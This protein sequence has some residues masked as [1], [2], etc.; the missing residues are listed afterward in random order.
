MVSSQHIERIV[1]HRMV[2]HLLFWLLSFYVL[3][4]VFCTDDKYVETDL[5]YTFLFHI[6]LVFLVY[7]NL[8]FLLPRYFKTKRYGRYIFGFA[9]VLALGTV[10]NHLT[11][12]YLADWLFEGYYFISYYQW[13]DILEFTFTYMALSTLLHLSKSWFELNE[14]KKAINRLEREKLDAELLSLKSQINPHFLFNSLNNLY[15]LSLDQDKRLP[16]LLLR[17]S[18]NLRYMLYESGDNFVPLQKEIQFL[19]NYIDLQRI[20][21]PERVEIKFAVQGKIKDKTIAPLL[22]IHFVEN[23]FKF[24]AKGSNTEAF[25]HINCEVQEDTF[26]F[27]IQNNK[28]KLAIPPKQGGGIGLSNT[29]KRLQLLYP[30][31]HHLRIEDKE[32]QFKVF[33]T[34]TLSE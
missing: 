21:A 28:G 14:K 6:S 8:N 20:R 4:R 9:V 24:G 25:V 13:G 12:Q 18:D 30:N 32:E 16:D 22:L 33:L 11:F 7:S 23:A 34:L 19:E 15:S 26:N 10:L 3:F 1:Q 2:Q 29:R 27:S 17:L 31:R 5:I